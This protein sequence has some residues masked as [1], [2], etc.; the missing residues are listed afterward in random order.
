MTLAQLK[1]LWKQWQNKALR[2]LFPPLCLSCSK[3]VGD[4]GEFCTTCWS[5]LVFISP[6]FCKK[7]GV[8]FD[9]KIEDDLLCPKCIQNSPHYD[10]VRSVFLYN[11]IS[12]KIILKLK[13]HDA[14]HL[15]LYMA[16]YMDQNSYGLFDVDIIAPVPLH[17]RRLLKRKFNQSELILK[18]LR[19]SPDQKIYDLLKRHK[20]TP[21][22]G[23]LGENDRI[24]NVKSAFK[25][26]PKYLKTI[27]G[28]KILLIDDMF[29]TG[30]TINE[31][32]KVLKKKGALEVLCLSFARA[33]RNSYKIL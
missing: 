16:Q 5:D 3:H 9:F 4:W 1:L 15:A 28:K 6:P 23:T 11:D 31:C 21:I 18:H 20:N 12:K 25:I 10:I 2:F 22:Q 17:W 32:A 30:A 14:T 33:N 27:K 13:H 19:I 29:T 26:N 24:A 7:C 8:P